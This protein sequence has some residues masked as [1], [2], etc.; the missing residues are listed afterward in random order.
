MIKKLTPGIILHL[1]VI[2][3]LLFISLILTSLGKQKTT[4]DQFFFG[5]QNL[6]KLFPPRDEISPLIEKEVANLPGHWSITI[7]DLKTG[8]AYSY[9]ETE[10]FPSASLYKLSVMWATL[11]AIEKNQLQ[12]DQVLS[13]QKTELDQTLEGVKN[14]QSLDTSEEETISYS[15]D[16]ALRL[17]ITISDNYSA[18]L[19][20]EK[21]GWTNIDQ[22]MEKERLSSFD[23]ESGSP[24]TTAQATQ[25]LLERIYR[26]SAVSRKVSEEMKTLLFAQKINDRISKYLSDDIKVGHK[27]GEL[28]DLRHD[29]GIILGKKSHYIFVFLSETPA[30]EEATETIAKLSK[31][32]FDAL[33]Q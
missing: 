31:K 9:K 13:G 26:G 32:I 20:G 4:F 33:E 30:P 21:L 18:I 12:K 25:D 2:I 27:T 14:N 17:M 5:S 19:L 24:K 28:G 3:I 22:L 1:L 8:Q 16:E 23:L 29:A 10:L 6:P 15:V 11:D 7:K